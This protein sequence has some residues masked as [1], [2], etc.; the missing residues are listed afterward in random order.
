MFSIKDDMKTGTLVLSGYFLTLRTDKK[1][2]RL[3]KPFWQDLALSVKLCP[4]T[5]NW[6]QL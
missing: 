2:F 1:R 3:H 6:S 4:Q 5:A